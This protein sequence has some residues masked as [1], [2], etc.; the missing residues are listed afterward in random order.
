MPMSQAQPAPLTF[1]RFWRWLQD[2]ANCLLRV[3]TPSATLFDHEDLHWD[4][5]DDEEGMGVVQLV[6]GK[7]LVGELL[8]EKEHVALV[9][10]QLD[11]EA[12]QQGQWVFEL[13]GGEK[14]PFP[15]CYFLMSHGLDS[16]SGHQ[17]LKH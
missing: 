2:H 9:Q 16:P 15:G 6:R 10:P 3:G 1:E 7:V 4:F 5:F 14:S 17:E 12:P 11:L 8:I 13:M